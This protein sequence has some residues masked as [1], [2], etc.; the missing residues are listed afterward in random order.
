MMF[1]HPIRDALASINGQAVAL[2]TLQSTFYHNE[3]VQSAR[4]HVFCG[5]LGML[6]LFRNYVE[7]L[8]QRQL[9]RMRE[10]F[11]IECA[12]GTW[13]FSN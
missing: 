6:S 8:G 13:R 5:N 1:R 10:G 3:V 7:R 4:I 9:A 11:R 12:P 2:P